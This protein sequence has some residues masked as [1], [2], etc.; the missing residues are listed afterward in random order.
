M[1]NGHDE[2]VVTDQVA[3]V[4]GGS[5]DQYKFSIFTFPNF[6]IIFGHVLSIFRNWTNLNE[7]KLEYDRSTER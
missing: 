2:V 4:A 6:I 3:P 1:V 7:V 5:D